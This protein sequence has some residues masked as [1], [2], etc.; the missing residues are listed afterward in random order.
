ME[1]KNVPTV[2]D[3]QIADPLSLVN[4]RLARTE[5]DVFRLRR[6]TVVLHLFVETPGRLQEIATMRVDNVILEDGKIRVMRK[7]RRQRFMP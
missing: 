3:E 7:C 4:P 5:L 6:I 2:S 1:E